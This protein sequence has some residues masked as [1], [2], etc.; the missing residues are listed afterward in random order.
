M[1]SC[2][3]MKIFRAAAFAAGYYSNTGV[4]T[5]V[6]YDNNNGT[7][8]DDFYNSSGT[9]T[10]QTIYN[11]D[12]ILHS[13]N[14]NVTAIN[15]TGMT[16]LDVTGST[17]VTADELSGF[18]ESDQW[19]RQHGYDLCDHGGQLQHHWQDCDRKLQPQRS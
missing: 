1:Y 11:A 5:E 15:T 10:G 12:N 17:S 4:N 8:I 2:Q 3:K 14:S 19:H 9:L 18:T 16:T 7:F 6:R 13:N